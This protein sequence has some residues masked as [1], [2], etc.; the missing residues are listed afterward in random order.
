MF[1]EDNAVK[2]YRKM[3]TF[4]LTLKFSAQI[5]FWINSS[6]R[7]LDGLVHFFILLI[8]SFRFRFI[9]FSAFTLTAIFSFLAILIV[10]KG[11]FNRFCEELISTECS[12]NH[13]NYTIFNLINNL[14][15][16]KSIDTFHFK[17]LSV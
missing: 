9:L 15:I 3:L 12:T 8:F 13:H 16:N 1:F 6:S 10:C 7:H 2:L 5:I 4:N 17:I 11:K 14:I